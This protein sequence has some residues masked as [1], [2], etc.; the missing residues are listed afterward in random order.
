[1][2]TLTPLGAAAVLSLA[3]TEL[4]D[5]NPAKVIQGASRAAETAIKRGGRQVTHVIG[6]GA[7][8]LHEGT[9]WRAE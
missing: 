2:A 6:K 1:M 7:V 3:D 5:Y 9:H 8:T 4:V